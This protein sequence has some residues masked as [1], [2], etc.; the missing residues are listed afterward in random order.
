[1]GVWPGARSTGVVT[2][3][4]VIERQLL[5]SPAA[6][7]SI[8]LPSGNRRYVRGVMRSMPDSTVT[9]AHRLNSIASASYD[10]QTG[11]MSN[12]TASAL[13]ITGAL[14]LRPAIS[15]ADGDPCTKYFTFFNF[16]STSHIVLGRTVISNSGHTAIVQEALTEE[17]STSE[18]TSMQWLTT[19]GNL[20]AGSLFYLEGKAEPS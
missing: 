13:R 20:R 14:G 16:P 7:I 3:F 18:I 1:M 4:E 12:G 5:V 19:S 2:S 11:R 15:F 8:S 10:T 9:V 6:S 17:V